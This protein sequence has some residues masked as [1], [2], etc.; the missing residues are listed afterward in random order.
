M[1]RPFDQGLSRTWWLKWVAAVD[2][3]IEEDG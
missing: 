1:S 2:A 3:T